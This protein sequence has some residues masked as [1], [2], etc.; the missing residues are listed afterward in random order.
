LGFIQFGRRPA[1]SARLWRGPTPARSFDHLKTGNEITRLFCA[2]APVVGLVDELADHSPP[3]SVCCNFVTAEQEN[4]SAMFEQAANPFFE[5]HAR[6]SELL[7]DIR[8]IGSD[9]NAKYKTT[10]RDLIESRHLVCQ[11]NW[12]A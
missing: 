3:A 10:F 12:I 7:A 5:R 8:H 9:A 4:R 11:E 6:C 1:G 2:C